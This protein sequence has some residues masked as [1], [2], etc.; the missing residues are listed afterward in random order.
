MH[1]RHP[2]LPDVWLITDERIGPELLQRIRRLPRGTG[3]LIR[4]HGLPPPERRALLRQVRTIAG[5]RGLVVL[6]DAKGRVARV[7]SMQELRRALPA[8]PDLLFLSPLFPTR[9]HPDWEPLGRMRA[10]ALVRI[11]KQPVLALGGMDAGR[12]SHLKK[13]GFSG[14]GGIDAFG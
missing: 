3:V 2:E 10:A 12:F 6:D 14:W 13:L 1:P 8:G 4:H 5:S 7:H 9:T 11:A